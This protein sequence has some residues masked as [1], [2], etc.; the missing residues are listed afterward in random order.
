MSGISLY[1][2]S[3]GL[4]PVNCYI[5]NPSTGIVVVGPTGT[6]SADV[7]VPQG[8]LVKDDYTIY[9]ASNVVGDYASASFEITALSSVSNTPQ[10]GAPGSSVTV[11]GANFAKIADTTV[12]VDL[13]QTDGTTLVVNLGTAKTVGD[14]SFSKAFTVPAQAFAPYK[15]R[16]SITTMGIKATSSLRN[17]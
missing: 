8:N 12:T 9:A 3:A 10:F 6:W 14:G 11:A 15:I 2:T 1:E 16:A 13:V 17:R 4:T 7:V 5:Y